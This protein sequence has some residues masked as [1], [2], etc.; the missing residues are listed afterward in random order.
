M[1]LNI[2]RN[3][4]NMEEVLELRLS[5]KDLIFLNLDAF[6]RALLEECGS[7]DKA[8]DKL[9]AAERIVFRLEQ[10]QQKPHSIKKGER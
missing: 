6:D 3:D 1:K 9:L 7:S 4:R 2:Y 8:S 10:Q 5:Q